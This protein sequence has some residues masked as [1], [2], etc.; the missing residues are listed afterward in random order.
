ML[1][2]LTTVNIHNILCHDHDDN[3][4]KGKSLKYNS[5]KAVK[6]KQNVPWYLQNKIFNIFAASEELRIAFCLLNP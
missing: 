4:F 6:I 3:Y 2:T 1:I 5:L